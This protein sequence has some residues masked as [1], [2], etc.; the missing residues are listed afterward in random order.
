MFKDV[1]EEDF[2]DFGK[3]N[4][5]WVI[6]IWSKCILVV[7]VKLEVYRKYKFKIN[8]EDIFL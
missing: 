5:L 2:F 7:E 1:F 4:I 8:K 3:E 6:L